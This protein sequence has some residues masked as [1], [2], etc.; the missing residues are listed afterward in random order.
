MSD[1]L[2]QHAIR[3]VWCTPD[4]DRQAIIKP[5]RYGKVRGV[6]QRIKIGWN[7]LSTPTKENYY[8]Y[9]IG[10][11]P[12]KLFGLNGVVNK[13]TAL[14]TLST[15]SKCSVN[16]YTGKGLV[17]P[18]FE[19]FIIQLENKTVLLAIKQNRDIP[20]GEED[21]FFHHYTNSFWNS[22]RVVDDMTFWV[23]GIRKTVDNEDAV[24]AVYNLYHRAKLYG[25][26]PLF[27]H[28]G[29]SVDVLAP[30]KIL[31]GD[32]I[33]IRV[34]DSLE[35]VVDVELDELHYNYSNL[36]N[37]RKYIVDLGKA[38]TIRY[39]DDIEIR[40]CKME[41]GVCKKGLLFHRNKPNNIRML[42]SAT[43]S[44][45]VDQVEYLR[46]LMDEGSCSL[47]FMVRK[48]G[49]KR[50]L[51][52][53]NSR[54]HELNK[55]P[56]NKRREIITGKTATCSLWTLNALEAS[57]YP[58][59]MRLPRID[60]STTIDLYRCYGYNAIAMY[61][62][63]NQIEPDTSAQVRRVATPEPYRSGTM[64]EYDS[65]G[66]LVTVK[67]TRGDGISYPES[68]TT[69]VEFFE[70]EALENC[71][72]YYNTL[73]VPAGHREYRLYHR[74]RG[75]QEWVDITSSV[76]FTSDGNGYL[77]HGYS[78]T[79]HDWVVRYSGWLWKRTF[80]VQ[81]RQGVLEVS[82]MDDEGT[83][84]LPFRNIIVR[85]NGHEL[86]KDIDF[87]IYRQTIWVIS[88]RYLKQDGTPNEV[89]VLAYGFPEDTDQGYVGWGNPDY[90]GWV[91][92][93]L[94]SVDDTYNLHTDHLY[95]AIVDGK[96]MVRR[97]VGFHEDSKGN[98][99]YM[100]NGAPYAIT[101]VRPRLQS[102]GVSES[103]EMSI[104]SDALERDRIVSDYL[105]LH[106]PIPAFPNVSPLS[107]RY[108][109]YSIFSARILDDLRSG[110]LQLPNVRL[111]DDMIRTL[112]LQYEYLLVA[113]AAYTG[114]NGAVDSGLATVRPHI[115]NSLIRVHQKVYS[116]MDRI[117]EIYLN[118]RVDMTG[119]LSIILNSEE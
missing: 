91:D 78:S 89:F 95:R 14:D 24:L 92:H 32:S 51:I 29:Y 42:A 69:I 96:F 53:E 3:N 80:D 119:H 70:D 61:G 66:Q 4:Q 20:L 107:E 40:V 21:I 44:V 6:Y 39:H 97:D 75:T 115:S 16:I 25:R 12:P 5:V 83:M 84:E 13:W 48:S 11:Y 15:E 109:L 77:N 10:H 94:L 38:D 43:Y 98:E 90:S 118:G 22:D 74:L 99:G 112:V 85:L 63:D 59:V 18:L 71:P 55:L 101:L 2:Q 86:V 30:G 72:D 1:F 67:G 108:Q 62:A 41:N 113:D 46:L 7:E 17:I 64:M 58:K 111:T 110:V 117:S 27:L 88:K 56:D 50:S 57:A 54:L 36:D 34:D 65:N 49:Y 52:L 102:L 76:T 37:I 114:L 104:R 87:V 9:Q 82:L 60:A 8:V 28:N 19:T 79:S 73:S 31:V 68:A 35:E 33:E 81:P 100:R 93:G 47:R 26:T 23:K 116:F 103:A 45:S 105:T 106:A